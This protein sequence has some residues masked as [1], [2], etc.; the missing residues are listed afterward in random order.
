MHEWDIHGRG[1]L[2]FEAFLSVIA[3]YLKVEQL[4]QKVE[5]DYLTISGL[6]KT[7]AHEVELRVARRSS[8]SLSDPE[9]FG[10]SEQKHPE[11]DNGEVEE[12]ITAKSLWKAIKK[13][14]PGMW[15]KKFTNSISL[16]DVEEMVYDADSLDQS[17]DM[18]VN[19]DELLNVLEMVAAD[20]IEEKTS[21]K[22]A[23]KGMIRVPTGR[24]LAA[25]LKMDTVDNELL[26]TAK[27]ASIKR[28]NS[29]MITQAF[30]KNDIDSKLD[31]KKYVLRVHDSTQSLSEV[32]RESDFLKRQKCCY[33]N[34]VV[35]S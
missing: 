28:S 2:D 25:L 13:Y 14:G 15:G 32:Q 21:N 5:E 16:A 12:E 19:L 17:G 30:T 1:Y 24:H 10:I 3:T 8:L 26:K 34:I 23:N 11:L 27:R 29:S 33:L 31:S 22:K 6:T 4:D 9:M 18:K 35:I 7:E 20:E